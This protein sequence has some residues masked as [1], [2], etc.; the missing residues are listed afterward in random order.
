MSKTENKNR[1]L[2]MAILH[3]Q[4]DGY[5]NIRREKIATALDLSCALV[6]FHYGTMKQLQRAVIGAAIARRNLSILGQ[7]LALK[8]PRA[9]ALP[10]DLKALARASL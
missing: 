3:A 9:M 10:D 5:Q 4:A 8:D 6:N 2:D 7:A 1:I